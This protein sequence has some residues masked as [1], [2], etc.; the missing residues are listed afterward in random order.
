[1]IHVWNLN[2]LV[3]YD[4]CNAG[5]MGKKSFILVFPVLCFGLSL[6]TSCD[7]IGDRDKAGAVPE[8]KFQRILDQAVT[9]Y[10]LPSA[11]LLIENPDTLWVGVS[12]HPNTYIT[13]D[14]SVNSKF[15]I[16]GVSKT[17]LSV[18]YLMLQ[19]EGV[20]HLD[21]AISSEV[22][23]Y[24]LDSGTTYRML[25]GHTSGLPDYFAHRDV[26]FTTSDNSS[27]IGMF[28]RDPEYMWTGKDILKRAPFPRP[29]L[30]K[31]WAYSNTNYLLA[32]KMIETMLA[33]DADPV[34]TPYLQDIY[35]ERIFQPLGMENT[36][37]LEDDQVIENLAHGFEKASNSV[38]DVTFF[39]PSIT[40]AAGSIVTTVEDLRIFLNAVFNKDLISKNSLSELIGPYWEVNYGLGLFT[41][42]NTYLGTILFNYG[43]IPGYRSQ[44]NYYPQ[45]KTLIILL[46][47][48]NTQPGVDLAARYIFEE[49]ELR[50]FY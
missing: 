26:T 50:L 12:N 32:G 39:H 37:F 14:M 13:A 20:L 40:N 11:I 6:F 29:P 49:L 38:E 47:N 15:R 23:D 45:R 8:D 17:F 2:Y 24:P 48:S 1:M 7:L 27:Q 16:G 18:L 22:Y 46:A 4:L 30:D 5:P 33:E 25:L 36:I 10:G 3:N 21:S 44:F 41:R 34:T 31:S 9:G 42:P 43:S 35:D 28:W 19:E